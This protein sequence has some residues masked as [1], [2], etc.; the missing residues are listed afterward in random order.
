MTAV[1]KVSLFGPFGQALDMLI[2]EWQPNQPMYEAGHCMFA[3]VNI[4]IDISPVWVS[5]RDIDVGHVP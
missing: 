2:A 4:V 3:R 1:V 5:C